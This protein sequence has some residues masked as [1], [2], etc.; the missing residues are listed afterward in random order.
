MPIRR[1]RVWVYE[2]PPVT[3]HP[4][5]NTTQTVHSG[6]GCAWS[7]GEVF[8]LYFTHCVVLNWSM[9]TGSEGYEYMSI[10]SV[11]CSI[12]LTY[13]IDNIVRGGY[14]WHA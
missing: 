1:V 5:I 10:T 6:L 2:A 12:S 8:F 4:I 13:C 14:R 3:E 7:S 9:H 11:F